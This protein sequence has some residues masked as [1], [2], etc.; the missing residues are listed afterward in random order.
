MADPRVTLAAH[1]RFPGELL[2]GAM[3]NGAS[4]VL[5]TGGLADFD[6]ALMAAERDHSEAMVLFSPTVADVTDLLEQSQSA[7]PEMALIVAMPGPPNGFISEALKAGADEIVILPAD[8]HTLAAAVHTALARVERDEQVAHSTAQVGT[9]APLVVVLGPKGGVGKTTVSTNI[10]TELASQGR[11]VLLIDLDLQFGDVGLVLGVEP[12]R[13]IYDLVTAS[14]ALDGDKLRGF[15]RR[16]SDGVEALLAPVRPDQAEAVT[17]AN[18]GELLEIACGEF[19]LVVVDTPPA[20]TPTTIAAIDRA[21][22]VVMVGALDLPGMKNMKV[23]LET[24]QLMGFPRENVTVALNR[25]DTK[26]GLDAADVKQVLGR[27][28]DIAIP[29]DRLIPRSI[30]MT[31]PIV[32]SDPKSPPAKALKGLADRLSTNLLEPKDA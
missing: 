3:P 21:S 31:R 30:N 15:L 22:H 13:T 6:K 26:V 23:G 1:A 25:S 28:P 14:G 7:R 10:A 32:M 2:D 11:R 29:S 12:D 19:E 18:L 24:L 17:I 20:F 5:V 27:A 16:S 4:G 8:G 9:A